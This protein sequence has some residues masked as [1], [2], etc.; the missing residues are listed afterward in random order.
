MAGWLNGWLA[1]THVQASPTWNTFTSETLS[2]S[3]RIENVFFEDFYDRRPRRRTERPTDRPHTF[4]ITI[5]KKR[6]QHQVSHSRWHPWQGNG[7]RVTVTATK[8]ECDKRT[9]ITN[10][11]W[12]ILKIAYVIFHALN[13]QPF[14][15]CS[16]NK[17][18]KTTQKRH[19]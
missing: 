3:Q 13:I 14:F 7:Q 10:D 16:K 11:N 19:V 5:A 6:T 8:N 17:R 9:L 12:I 15:F 1:G 2:V 18:E 4:C